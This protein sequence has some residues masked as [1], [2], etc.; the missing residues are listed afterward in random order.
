MTTGINKLIAYRASLTQEQKDNLL[1]EARMAAKHKRELREANKHLVRTEYLDAGHWSNLASKY[2]VRMP[3]Q[4]DATSVK[5]LRKYL[6]RCN[7]SVETFN[8]HYTS[9]TYF[10]KNNPRWSAYATAG[11][12][13]E[14]KES[15]K[16]Y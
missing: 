5:V 6:K 3:H 8:E 2:G 1:V 16:V 7:V 10:V 4:D 14:L 13:L 12:I 15:V 9:M 11:I